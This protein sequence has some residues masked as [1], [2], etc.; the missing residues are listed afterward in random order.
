MGSG[1]YGGGGGGGSGAGAGS[2][3]GSSSGG[4]GGRGSK[5]GRRAV[6]AIRGFLFRDGRARVAAVSQNKAA[7]AVRKAFAHLSRNA[8]QY[9]LAQFCSPIVRT[10]FEQIFLLAPSIFQDRRWDLIARQFNVSSGA[11]C[12][13]RL[14]ERI[15]VDA[16]AQEPNVKVRETIRMVLEDFLITA[17]GNNIDL[18]VSGDGEAVVKAMD[19]KVF[20]SASGYFLGALIW[21]VLE[22]ET[23]SLPAYSTSQLRLAAQESADRIVAKFET[24]FKVGQVTHRQLFRIFQDNSEWLLEE[25]RH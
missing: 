3:A 8:K 22:R 21:R 7:D 15:V 25:L 17:L 24:R 23:E 19:E 5:S 2:G 9:V 14:V 16:A 18:Y 13:Q 11:G 6:L 10:V 4:S 1:S 20:K 12:L